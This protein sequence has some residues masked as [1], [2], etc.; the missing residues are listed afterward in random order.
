MIATRVEV[1]KLQHASHG[2]Q[3]MIF[4]IFSNAAVVDECLTRWCRNRPH[5]SSHLYIDTR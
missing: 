3:E 1:L 4:R 5:T 2:E